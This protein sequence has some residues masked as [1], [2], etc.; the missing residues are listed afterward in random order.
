MGEKVGTTYKL[1]DEMIYPIQI[2]IN[3][4]LEEE[5]G[6]LELEPK[7]PSLTICV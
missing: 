5:S 7:I 1:V 6:L 4:Y 3:V 2:Y